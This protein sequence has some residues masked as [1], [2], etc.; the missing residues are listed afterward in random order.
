[1][2]NCLTSKPNLSG[3]LHASVVIKYFTAASCFPFGC[4]YRST[5]DLYFQIYTSTKTVFIH[6]SDFFTCGFIKNS[7]Q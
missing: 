1:M 3:L 2:M 6:P 4:K 5:L 7:S